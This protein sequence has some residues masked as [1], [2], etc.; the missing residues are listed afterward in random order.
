MTAVAV[1]PLGSGK[2]YN[3]IVTGY[4]GGVGFVME[5]GVGGETLAVSLKG[6]SGDGTVVAFYV[7]ER[8][9]RRH[10]YVLTSNHSLVLISIPKVSTI[11]SRRLNETPLGSLADYRIARSWQLAGPLGNDNNHT[12]SIGAVLCSS[13]LFDRFVTGSSDSTIKLWDAT[14]SQGCITTFSV[15]TMGVS[16]LACISEEVDYLYS[17]GNDGSVKLIC[18][19]D[20]TVQSFEEHRGPILFVGV[21]RLCEMNVAVSLCG[22]GVL[23]VRSLFKGG[24][25]AAVC[26]VESVSGFSMP[27]EIASLRCKASAGSRLCVAVG[28]VEG[29]VTLLKVV[30]QK[31]AEGGNCEVR[32][33]TTAIPCSSVSAVNHIAVTADGR[34]VVHATMDGNVVV[35]TAEQTPLSMAASAGHTI[36]GLATLPQ[37]EEAAI[38]SVVVGTCSRKLSMFA[39]E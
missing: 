24:V 12:G 37:R 6:V 30:V 2:K 26:L 8:R 32:S 9:K 15:H 1:F 10:L 27:T 39:W 5:S 34:F 29:N 21:E 20:N 3:V 36:T 18:L 35:T 31:G 11:N 17:G 16:C 25:K 14:G 33:E 7:T 28:H 22:D 38:P 4:R 19:G 13:S 23:V